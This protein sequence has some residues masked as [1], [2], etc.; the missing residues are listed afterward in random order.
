MTSL[1]STTT[2]TPEQKTAAEQLIAT[3]QQFDH[4]YRSPYLSN[5]FNV[6]PEMKSFF[7]AY[8]HE[9]LVGI[10]TLYADEPVDGTVDVTANVLPTYRRRKIATT[11]WQEALN[12]L[13][14]FGYHDYEFTTERTFLK[15]NPDFLMHSQLVEADEN[16]FQLRHPIESV[17]LTH[18]PARAPHLL[19]E[20]D[21]PELV[22]QFVAAFP[23]NEE[24]G[25]TQYLQQSLT[26]PMTDG[27]VFTDA[28]QIVGACL[29]DKS[30]GY[31]FFSLF[32]KPSKQNQGLG[33]YFVKLLSQHLIET[34]PQQLVIGVEAD[35][36]PAL[37]V[38]QKAGFEIETEVLYL[39]PKKIGE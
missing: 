21:V 7:L 24:A 2:L 33:T 23:R 1:I 31:Y 14:Q 34:A 20:S 6:F 36:L 29:V 26:D 37:H 39:V 3:V 12:E 27:Y 17:I 28:D 8:D 13:H 32:I 16:E 15:A 11:L 25:A 9:K 18:Q 35:N 5:Q 4:T 19:K 30:D 22:T 38:Y 10:V